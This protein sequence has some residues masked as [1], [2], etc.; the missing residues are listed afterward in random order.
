MITALQALLINL[1]LTF[2]LSV[3]NSGISKQKELENT[4]T[5][6]VIAFLS[7]LSLITLPFTIIW[8]ILTYITI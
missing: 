1:V 2:F 7:G 5:A 8:C 3:M 4:S 6:T